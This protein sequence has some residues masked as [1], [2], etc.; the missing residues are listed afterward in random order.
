MLSTGRRQ[1]VFLI[2]IKLTRTIS[3]VTLPKNLPDPD[4]LLGITIAG[5]KIHL[6]MLPENR[7][8]SALLILAFNRFKFYHHCA[9]NELLQIS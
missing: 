8:L 2:G 7:G 1:S 5:S 4:L 3:P 6:R 9:L